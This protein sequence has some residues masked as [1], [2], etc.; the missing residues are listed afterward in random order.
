MVWVRRERAYGVVVNAL[1][2]GVEQRAGEV[3]VRHRH[4]IIECPQ[5]SA[6][7]VR[8]APEPTTGRRV[9]L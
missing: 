7:A 2:T 9:R 6:E 8:H 5:R 1:S 3:R 4:R